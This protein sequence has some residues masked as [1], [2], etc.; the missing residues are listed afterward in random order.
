MRRFA[1][2]EASPEESEAPDEAVDYVCIQDAKTLQA[3]LK[4]IEQAGLVA[5]DLETDSLNPIGAQIIGMSRSAAS[6]N[7]SP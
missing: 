3:W 6:A 4:E 5:F 1:E 7:R 2:Y